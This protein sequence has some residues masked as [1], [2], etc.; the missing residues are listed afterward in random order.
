MFA[1]QYTKVLPIEMAGQYLQATVHVLEA[2]DASA[3]IKISAVKAVLKYGFIS[4]MLCLC[5]IMCLRHSFCKDISDSLL[6]PV[7]PRIAMAVGPFLSVTS[8][9]TL[10]LVLEALLTIVE[11]RKCAWMTQDLA[12]SLVSAVLDIWTKNNK[13]TF[14]IRDCHAHG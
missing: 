3:P 14:Y 5:L 10:S 8:E 13:G 12:T 4:M 11:I 2:V 7:A 1:S 9:D 6:E